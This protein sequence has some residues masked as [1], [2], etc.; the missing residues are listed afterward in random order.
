[1]ED[2]SAASDTCM[3][4]KLDD[5]SDLACM[6]FDKSDDIITNSDIKDFVET[7][8]TGGDITKK[9]KFEIDIDWAYLASD[10][11]CEICKKKKT[12]MNS[13]WKSTTG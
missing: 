3:L 5:N 4:I 10:K 13:I 7:M 1:M 8:S 2:K 9:E 11:V 12:T 6:A